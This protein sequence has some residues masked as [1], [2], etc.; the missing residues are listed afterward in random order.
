[1]RRRLLVAHLTAGLSEPRCAVGGCL[2][3]CCGQGAGLSAACRAEPPEPP[4]TS[5]EAAAVQEATA[6]EEA[7]LQEV[8]RRTAERR[9]A[10]ER[11]LVL[12]LVATAAI[13]LMQTLRRRTH[14]R[15]A[16]RRLERASASFQVPMVR[17]SP[18][19]ASSNTTAA[20]ASR[21]GE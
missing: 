6:I 9:R 15:R 13:A 5:P 21:V 10:H 14:R 2:R 11:P 19:L 17:T 8:E 4:T 20:N 12:A 3:G 7:V 18:A 16:P 1:M